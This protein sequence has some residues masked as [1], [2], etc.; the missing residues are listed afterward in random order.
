MFLGYGTHLTTGVLNASSTLS[1]ST[2]ATFV[3]GAAVR[4]SAPQA[5]SRSAGQLGTQRPAD[6][7]AQV[8]QACVVPR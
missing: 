6:Q 3:G 7:C 4:S 1:H 5:G 8:G 2:R